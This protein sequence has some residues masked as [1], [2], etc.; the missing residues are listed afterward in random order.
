MGGDFA[1]VT[2]SPGECC[3]TRDTLIRAPP[4]PAAP[5]HETLPQHISIKVVA[6]ACKAPSVALANYHGAVSHVCEGL[7]IPLVEQGCLGEVRNFVG[8]DGARKPLWRQSI[9]E[10]NLS[11]SPHCASRMDAELTKQREPRNTMFPER[12]QSKG[13]QPPTPCWESCEFMMCQ[14]FEPQH[15]AVW[16][17]T[18]RSVC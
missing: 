14:Q 5:I 17:A 12:L 1:A 10:T 16:W 13:S 18:I 7:M 3:S 11:L 6:W 4:P 9:L 8:V 2:V 15:I